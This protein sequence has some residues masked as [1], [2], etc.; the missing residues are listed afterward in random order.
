MLTPQRYLEILKT[1]GRSLEEIGV[2]GVALTRRFALDAVASLRGTQV[3][4]VGGDVLVVDGGKPRYT[5]DNW[6]VQRLQDED[7]FA[8]IARS[9]AKAANYISNYR[10]PEDGSVL[11]AIVASELGL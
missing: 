8:Y 7:V 4:V 11:Y 2:R 1:S 5:G 9:H 3:A 6:Y 10:D